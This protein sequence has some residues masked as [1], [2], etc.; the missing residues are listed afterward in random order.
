MAEDA[1]KA[2]LK[3][4][5]LWAGGWTLIQVLGQH[6]IRLGSNLIMTRLLVPEAFGLIALVGTLVTAFGLLS[7]IGISRSIVREADGATPHF[8]RAA[9]VVKIGRG[10]MIAACVLVSALALFLTGHLWAPDE[11]VYAAPEL[12]GLIALSALVPV[13]MGVEA[14]TKELAQRN[15][16]YKRITGLEISARVISILSMIMFA[17]LSPTAWALL[18]GMLMFIVINSLGSH[19]VF[20]G[21]R[22]AVVWDREISQRL[23]RYGKWLMGSSLLTFLSRNADKFI[24]GGFL[25]AATF[26]LYVIAQIWISAG[27][28]VVRKLNEQVGFSSMGEVIRT[29]PEQLAKQFLK[30]QTIIDLICVSGFLAC[31]FLGPLLINTLYPEAYMQAGAFLAL[32]AVVF[33]AMRFTLLN[34]LLMNLGNSRAMMLVSALQAIMMCV[35]LPLAYTVFGLPAALLVVSLTPL[36]GAPY[37]LRLVKPTLGV[38]QVRFGYLWIGFTLVVTAL[39]FWW[40]YTTI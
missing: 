15:L 24:L 8:L 36:A 12:S 30:L 16:S 40:L 22:M 19:V 13:L 39:C 6:V 27:M 35:G 32:L 5:T 37:V 20:P 34:N 25:D 14:T 26:G 11:S 29:R 38:G 3:S 10:M 33:L 28:M 21:P 2:S 4:R 18:A 1:P 17:Y 7:D 9:W 31:L 23:W